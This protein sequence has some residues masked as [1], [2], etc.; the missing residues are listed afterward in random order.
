MVGGRV[1]T[2]ERVS[3]TGV[4]DPVDVAHDHGI[5]VLHPDVVEHLARHFARHR[6]GSPGAHGHAVAIGLAA[7]PVP[8]VAPTLG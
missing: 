6:G 5:V 4:G 1:R 7:Y 3:G 2:A 8:V